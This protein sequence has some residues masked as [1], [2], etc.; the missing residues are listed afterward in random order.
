MKESSFW[1]AVLEPLLSAG[2]AGAADF[3]DGAL[4]GAAGFSDD[5]LDAGFSE[6]GLLATA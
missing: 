3:S 1:A 5:G 6:G 4:A 2:F